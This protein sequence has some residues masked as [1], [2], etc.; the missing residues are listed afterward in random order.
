MRWQQGHSVSAAVDIVM[1]KP[2]QYSMVI[3]HQFCISIADLIYSSFVSCVWVT[4]EVLSQCGGAGSQPC[5]TAA[6]LDTQL[7]WLLP[8]VVVFQIYWQLIWGLL[9]PHS[10][11]TCTCTTHWCSKQTVSDTWF[12]WVSLASVVPPA[13]GVDRPRRGR[14]MACALLCKPLLYINRDTS[15]ELLA[16]AHKKNGRRFII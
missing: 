16:V 2:A 8:P 15:L 7:L 6:S 5:S 14:W 9:C 4:F 13:T 12:R 1:T 10:W 11:Q 3:Q